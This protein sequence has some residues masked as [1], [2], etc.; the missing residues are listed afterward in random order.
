ML[1]C[2]LPEASTH[3][4]AVFP[5]LGWTGRSGGGGGGNLGPGVPGTLI[6]GESARQREFYPA[7]TH[8]LRGSDSWDIDAVRTFVKCQAG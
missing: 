8:E 5:M 7:S 4:L 1:V 2:K 6:G 3:A